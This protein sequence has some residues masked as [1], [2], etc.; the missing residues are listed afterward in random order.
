VPREDNG[1]LTGAETTTPGAE[2]DPAGR[3]FATMTIEES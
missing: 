1:G 3:D 2:D